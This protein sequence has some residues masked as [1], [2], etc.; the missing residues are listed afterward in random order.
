[1]TDQ[2]VSS[3]VEVS[4]F[5]RGAEV[6]AF[7]LSC[8]LCTLFWGALLLFPLC[9]LCCNWWK[10][11][12]FPLYE[13]PSSL[14][15]NLRRLLTGIHIRKASLVVLDN[16]LDSRKAD[17]LYNILA[18]STLRGFTLRN[19]A[20]NCDYRAKEYSTFQENMLPI[21]NLPYL[22]TDISWDSTWCL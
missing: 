5:V 7:S 20:L 14:Y 16:G 1:M 21:R 6:S 19:R 4:L 3:I 15:L 11:C 18:S 9:C 10:K 22:V 2:E 12:V 13:V 8:F 17:I